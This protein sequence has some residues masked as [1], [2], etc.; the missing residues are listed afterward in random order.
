MFLRGDFQVEALSEQII[1]AMATE[2]FETEKLFIHARNVYVKK[3][4]EDFRCEF[5][6]KLDGEWVQIDASN[7]YGRAREA[8][9]DIQDNHAE[10]AGAKGEPRSWRGLRQIQEDYILGE[11]VL[12]LDWTDQKRTCKIHMLSRYTIGTSSLK[13]FSKVE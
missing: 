12:T 11:E 4:P 9:R 5:C 2:Q 10:K 13:I 7:N 6:F 3:E 1:R 8:L